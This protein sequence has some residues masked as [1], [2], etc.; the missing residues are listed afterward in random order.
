MKAETARLLE[1][2]QE[3]KHRL[4]KERRA[5]HA[6]LDATKRQVCPERMEVG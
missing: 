2:A 3:T 4:E 1:E 5:M 6:E